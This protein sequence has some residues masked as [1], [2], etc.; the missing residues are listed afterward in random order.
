MGAP[1]AS[2]CL[3]EVM[4]RVFG[5]LMCEGFVIIKDDDLYVG[6]N[7]IEEL[8][9][10]WEKV[11]FRFQEND[12]TVAAKK[13]FICPIKV[14][15]LGW[16]WQAG[17]L[18]P[19]A[20][21][22]APLSTVKPPATATSMRSFLGAYKAISRC[23][24]RYAS[25]LSP[26]EDALRGLKGA[27]RIVWSPELTKHFE[28]AQ[29]A[30]TSPQTIT[31][32]V[33][34]DALVLTVD[35]SP[36]NRGLAATLFVDR[37]AKRLIADFYSFKLKSHHVNW[38]PCEMEALA[39]TSAIEHFSPY[40]RESQ[41]PVK[42]LTDNRPCV[43]AYKKLT[44]GKFSASARL[45]TF[46]SMLSAYRVEICH[47]P[48]KKNIT[49]DF[50]SRN[51]TECQDASCQ[52][53]KFVNEVAQSTVCTISIEDVLSGS[54]RM[55]FTNTN[56]W[57]SAQHDSPILRRLF[58]HLT[59]GTRPGK[60]SRN[61][62]DLRKYLSVASVDNQGLLIVRKPDPYVSHKD[63]IIVP[64]Q[65]LPGIITAIHLR[66]AHPT[67]LQMTKIFDRYFY[68]LRSKKVIEEVVE[69][70]S[71]CN[72]MKYIAP[73]LM[74]QT[75]SS[76][77]EHPGDMF[78]ADVMR[79]ALQKILVVRDYHSSYT[80]TAIIPDETANSLRSGLLISTNLL[81]RDQ[82]VIRIDNAPGFLP[83]KNDLQLK[84]HGIHLDLGRKKNQNKNPV[85]DK[86]IQ[87]LEKEILRHD[88]SGAIV[89][90]LTLQL[91]TGQL[92]C[93]IRDRGLSAKEVILQREQVTGKQLTFNDSM[94]A[95]K[96]HESR[97]RNHGPSA[98][99]KARAPAPPTSDIVVG[100]LVYVKSELNKFKARD[101]Y[102]VMSMDDGFAK[103][104][105]LNN[106]KLMS[107]KYTVPIATIFKIF[108]KDVCRPHSPDEDVLDSES[109]SEYE[110]Y[111]ISA[112]PINAS[113]TSDGDDEA[114]PVAAAP[115]N[116]TAAPTRQR[117]PPAWMRSGDYELS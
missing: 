20:H 40:I 48:G 39:I 25:L 12:L 72:S 68:G 64:V 76:V 31:I 23:I 5:D 80:T 93:M 51:P 29:K 83:L 44:Q 49:S 65:L 41:N 95:D 89:S 13:T 73:E 42:I 74:T 15:I 22:I 14:T 43:Q 53:C 66:F 97:L 11:L 113:D 17:T 36:V 86:A 71:Q 57:K 104:Q 30:L 81:R 67:A 59:S 115:N 94:L 46:L 35:A 62:T 82:C 7:S 98:A 106:D 84:K 77:V 75:T 10:H 19:S 92:N 33:P 85:A 111:P 34:S 9:Q 96:Q 6:G 18:S 28:A 61:M 56:A 70:C 117:Q 63:L 60:K 107:T 4:C 24:P 102:I 87:E 3:R 78:A 38:L 103:I 26:L 100:D 112:D 109:D 105:K 54:A 91:I 21:K 101:R 90:D 69:Q 37:A 47:I 8:F 108:P 55:P 52:I 27:Q 88:P 1:G 45:S 114:A 2:E 116:D 79:R 32:P 99:S 16:T 110:H 50:G 58:A